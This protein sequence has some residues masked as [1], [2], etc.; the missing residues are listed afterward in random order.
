MEGHCGQE[1]GSGLIFE[2]L[3]EEWGD[4]LCEEF[5]AIGV[6]VAPGV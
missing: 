6:D 5:I 4:G 1:R 2:G 3:D